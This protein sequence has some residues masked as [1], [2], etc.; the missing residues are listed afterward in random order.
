MTVRGG[1]T[2]V[3]NRCYCCIQLGELSAHLFGKELFIR[4]TVHVFLKFYGFVCVL[5]SFLALKVECGI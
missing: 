3:E 1:S 2:V 4:F 5:L